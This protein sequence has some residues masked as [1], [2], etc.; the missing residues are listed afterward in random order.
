MIKIYSKPSCIYCAAAKSLMGYKNS[1]YKEI[2][3]STT[4]QLEDIRTMFPEA[5]TFPIILIDDDYIGGLTE[6]QKYY[7]QTEIKEME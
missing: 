6:L 3:I 1:S 7:I 5:T 2:M 4:E